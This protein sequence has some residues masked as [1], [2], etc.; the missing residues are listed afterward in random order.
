MGEG[1]RCAD[2]AFHS[3]YKIDLTGFKNSKTWIF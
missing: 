3:E 1:I 2:F